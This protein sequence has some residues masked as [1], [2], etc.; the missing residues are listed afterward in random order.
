MVCRAL[1]DAGRFED[2]RGLLAQRT[3]TK[4]NSP[5]GWRWYAEALE[6]C[7]DGAG[8]AAAREKAA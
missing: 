3:A 6:G 1:L 8:A 5:I 7:G 2:A 4:Q